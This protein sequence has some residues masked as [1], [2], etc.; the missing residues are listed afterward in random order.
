MELNILKILIHKIINRTETELGDLTDEE[1]ERAIEESYNEVIVLHIKIID[2]LEDKMQKFE[3]YKQ[4][5]KY[6]DRS[7]FDVN[8]D[9]LKY[10]ISSSWN[11]GCELY[12]EDKQITKNFLSYSHML[13]Q[14]C[15]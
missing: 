1:Y 6:I 7:G 11:I 8:L 14:Q 13:L 2:I 5:A 10:L 12:R 3:Y 15:Q 9:A 4:A